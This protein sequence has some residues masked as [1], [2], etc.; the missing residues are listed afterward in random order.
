MILL[1]LN[2]VYIDVY[3]IMSYLVFRKPLFLCVLLTVK[4][5]TE[6]W[7]KEGTVFH[8]G[9]FVGKG[10]NGKNNSIENAGVL[11]RKIE[12]YS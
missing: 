4:G 9:G 3:F 8:P 11:I 5:L 6:N 7:G 1:G 10:E 12:R 2:K